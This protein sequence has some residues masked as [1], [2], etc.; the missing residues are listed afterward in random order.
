MLDKGQLP[1]LPTISAGGHLVR[2][3]FEVGPVEQGAAGP[4]VLSHSALRDWQDSMG[5]SLPPWQLNLLRRLSADWI[6]E[7]ERA[8][9]PVALAP[10][11]VLSADDRKTVSRNLD[12]A[13]AALGVSKPKDRGP[14]RK[15]GA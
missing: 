1:E 13:F 8:R 6:E 12:K 5:L 9:N 10:G 7:T 3:L 15:R 14:R 11:Q 2:Y 4:V